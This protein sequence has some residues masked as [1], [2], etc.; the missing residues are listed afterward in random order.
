MILLEDL[1]NK[2]TYV[3]KKD[4]DLLNYFALSSNPAI[5]VYDYMAMR[6]ANRDLKEE[7]IRRAWHPSRVAKWLEA[8]LD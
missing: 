5:F 2:D 3:F 4:Y 6:E 1:I 7:L 8:G